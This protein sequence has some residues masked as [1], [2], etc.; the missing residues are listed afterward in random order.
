MQGT[1]RVSGCSEA[2][3]MLQQM[4]LDYTKAAAFMLSGLCSVQWQLHDIR[5]L[6]MEREHVLHCV[7]T[8]L[9]SQGAEGGQAL[10]HL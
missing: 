7:Q 8:C 10:V 9:S 6:G 1:V 2:L 3:S 5:Y 4:T